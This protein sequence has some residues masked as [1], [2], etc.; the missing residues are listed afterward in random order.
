MTINPMQSAHDAPRCKA[1]SKRTGKRC[2]A[3]AI[4]GSLVCRMHGARGG[5]PT[6]ERN[7]NYRNGAR[8]KEA[9]E[10]VRLINLLSR[11]AR[12]S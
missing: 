8:T 12:K 1:K 4:R 3:P 5:A 2:G 7:G 9:I 11:L 10:A 6:G